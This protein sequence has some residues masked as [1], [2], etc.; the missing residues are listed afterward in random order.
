MITEIKFTTIGGMMMIFNSLLS[1]FVVDRPI[2]VPISPIFNMRNHQIF[3]QNAHAN[4][5]C[6]PKF[7]KPN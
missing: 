6:Y 1:S 7:L 3:H 2:L 4:P 5:N